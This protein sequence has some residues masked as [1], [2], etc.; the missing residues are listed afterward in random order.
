MKPEMAVTVP[1]H[2]EG[3]GH[4]AP[5]PSPGVPPGIEG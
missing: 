2:E 4:T 5:L 1:V 3:A